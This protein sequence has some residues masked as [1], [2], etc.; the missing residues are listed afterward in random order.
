MTSLI[1]H[2]TDDSIEKTL[3]PKC[4]KMHVIKLYIITY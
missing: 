3:K 4:K 2:M 1:S